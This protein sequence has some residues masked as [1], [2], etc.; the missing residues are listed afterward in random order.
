MAK[1]KRSDVL[2]SLRMV[3]ERL[4]TA[5]LAPA[6]EE[7]QPIAAASATKSDAV[8]LP[9]SESIVASLST[10]TEAPAAEAE[11][12]LSPIEEAERSVGFD[13]LV[14][15][16]DPVAAQVDA[17]SVLEAREELL[18]ADQPSAAVEPP[19]ESFASSEAP[20]VPVQPYVP[21]ASVPD[22][23]AELGIKSTGLNGFH[24]VISPREYDADSE[25]APVENGAEAVPVAEAEPEPAQ[26]ISTEP[27]LQPEAREAIG[28]EEEMAPLEASEEANGQA[29]A[30][31]AIAAVEEAPEVDT[32]EAIRSGREGGETARIMQ[33]FDEPLTWSKSPIEE[34]P[35]PDVSSSEASPGERASD[36]EVVNIW[37]PELRMPDDPSP[38]RSK[39]DALDSYQ[40]SSTSGEDDPVARAMRTIE[41]F[42]PAQG[43]TRI[44]PRMPEAATKPLQTQTVDTAKK[45]EEADSAQPIDWSFNFEDDPEVTFNWLP[46]RGVGAAVL[47]LL[48]VAGACFA[49]FF[50]AG[51]ATKKSVSQ[52]KPAPAAKQSSAQPAENSSKSAE[53]EIRAQYGK[54]Y[55]A[56]ASN[57]AAYMELLTPDF[58]FVDRNHKVID[59]A[60]TESNVK[61]S[62]SFWKSVNSWGTEVLDLKVEGNQASATIAEEFDNFFR[63][64]QGQYGAKGQRRRFISKDMEFRDHWVKTSSGWKLERSKSVKAPTETVDGKPVKA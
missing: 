45:Q 53:K 30:Q 42:A 63:D 54:L 14:P 17:L 38:V 8:E 20:T 10:V 46:R 61:K 32:L 4:S 7:E 26:A 59:R 9:I 43:P 23:A 13:G 35:A 15:P 3:G 33:E 52:P 22:W 1:T 44:P 60:T 27:T 57:P 49:V 37:A 6:D 19:T 28:S 41:E 40:F 47:V 50:F 29:D 64:D 5:R 58:T 55:K 62:V 51:T 18:S 36:K 48:L 11:E 25:A 16:P 31:A 21:N 2:A 56:R 39:Q 34:R 24:S 12:A